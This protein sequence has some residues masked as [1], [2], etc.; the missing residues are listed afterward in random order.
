MTKTD[1]PRCRDCKHMRQDR[2]YASLILLPVIGWVLAPMLWAASLSNAR[3]ALS[4]F[5]ARIDPVSGRVDMH[6]RYCAEMR[7]Y[8]LPGYCGPKGRHFEARR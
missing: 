2:F 1:V 3:C 7:G 5:P 6:T 8:D 4:G